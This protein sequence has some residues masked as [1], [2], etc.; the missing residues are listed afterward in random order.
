VPT[1]AFCLAFAI[2]HRL[3]HT[4][5]VNFL[6]HLYLSDPTP[7]SMIG[8]LLPD[9]V[10]GPLDPGLH[11]DVLAGAHNHKRV[12]AFTDTHPLFARTRA[13]LRPRHGRYSAILTDLFYDH[14][15]ARHWN[16]YHDQP[17]DDFIDRTHAALAGHTHLM[18]DPMP[19]ITGRMIEQDWMRSYTTIDGMQRILEMMSARF[20]E[21]LGRPVQ[22]VHAVEDLRT[23]G[24][25]IAD[26]FE[27]FF[28]QLT[29]YVAGPGASTLGR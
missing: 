26:D 5:C 1:C 2:I 22:L 4:P 25:G 9:L 18:P 24:D 11:P 14:A 13:R 16:R 6:A 8:N 28:P 20:S 7:G 17:L 27:A 21:R 12:D 3:D 19:A 23:H 10:P 15:L 29:A